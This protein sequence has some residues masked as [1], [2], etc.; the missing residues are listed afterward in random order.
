MK[1]ELAGQLSPI[2]DEREAWL[3]VRAA[4]RGTAAEPHIRQERSLQVEELP[5][6]NVTI[7]M[8]E[9]RLSES[10]RVCSGSPMEGIGRKVRRT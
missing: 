6:E 7:E 5:P 1:E 2:L 8:M 9:H 4:I 10:G 3:S